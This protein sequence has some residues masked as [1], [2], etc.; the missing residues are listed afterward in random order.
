[1]WLEPGSTVMDD[2]AEVVT[3]STADSPAQA[4]ELAAGVIQRLTGDGARWREIAVACTDERYVRALR[5][6][7]Q[8]AGIG[9]YF[10]GTVD[11]LQKPLLQAILSAMQAQAGFRMRT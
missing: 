2:Q 11:I 8:R 5:P 4:C 1:M 3:L 7:L 10:A 6:M 9:A